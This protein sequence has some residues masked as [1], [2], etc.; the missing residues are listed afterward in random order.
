MW[1][2]RLVLTAVVFFAAAGS[3]SASA[4][5][6]QITRTD[7]PPFSEGGNELTAVSCATPSGCEALGDGN[8]MGGL[9]LLG[10]SWNGMSW[11]DVSSNTPNF[12]TSGISAT[13]MSCPSVQGCFGVG[14][15]SSPPARPTASC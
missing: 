10:Q 1:G 8:S 13:G 14:V 3:G 6:W 5:N 7:N 15:N 11:T 4:P 2:A 12:S 9:G